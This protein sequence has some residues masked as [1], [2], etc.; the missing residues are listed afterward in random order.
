M[1]EQTH[2][3][4]TSVK[5]VSFIAFGMHAPERGVLWTADCCAQLRRT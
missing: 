3:E 5:N 2:N 1:G 4:D